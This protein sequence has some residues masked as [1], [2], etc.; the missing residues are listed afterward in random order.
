M[1]RLLA[2]A[3][4]WLW[5]STGVRADERRPLS[6]AE[7]AQLALE[8]NGSFVIQRADSALYDA[9]AMVP[10]KVWSPRLVGDLKYNYEHDPGNFFFPEYI[11]QQVT[12]AVALEGKLPLGTD[13]RFEWT[14]SRDENDGH[15]SV[16]T[17]ANRTALRLTFTQPLLRNAWL[18]VNKAPISIASLRRDA[19]RQLRQAEA[20][21]IVAEVELAYWT[22]ATALKER[23]VREAAVQLAREQ[24]ADAQTQ[25][26]HGAVSQIDVVEAEA[27]VA[28]RLDEVEGSN[29]EIAEADGRF[30]A[31]LQLSGDQPGGDG[32]VSFVP[33]DAP[34]AP[35]REVSLAEALE[36]AHRHRPDLAAA[37]LQ[38]EVEK[39]A[40]SVARNKLW[41]SLDLTGAIG[42][43]GFSG[44]L[45]TGYGTASFGGTM[46]ITSTLT[47]QMLPPFLPDPSL[48]GGLDTMF[49]N[50]RFLSAAVGLH[51]DVPLDNGQA[52]A[53]RD[54][55]E[56]Q[57]RKQQGVLQTLE[58]QVN[59][60]V[61]AAYRRM[62][63]DRAR[64]RATAE[65]AR[66]AEQLLEGQRKRFRN[67][68]SVSFDVLRATDEVTRA[69][70]AHVRA[71]LSGRISQARLALAEGLYL[72]SHHITLR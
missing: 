5:W 58:R 43:T 6:L 23:E 52:V 27:A 35:A 29:Q 49:K 40:L 65:V 25:L 64:I 53:N 67:G 69:R 59:A 71:L 63:A 38:I 22:V 66:L 62:V 19:S 17:P 32:R 15:F 36:T 60:Q 33:S 26:K 72:D 42:L 31:V 51:L 10:R 68:V 46:P 56:A 44:Q 57:V 54:V 55:A 47:G 61:I 8:N 7:A 1:R 70:L 37:R 34:D 24:V 20:E 2:L 13:Y 16:Y 45:S 39:V 4:V 11:D 14:F 50:W 30:L 28:R 21:R 48:Q 41:P 12:A 9:Q 3:A 18:S